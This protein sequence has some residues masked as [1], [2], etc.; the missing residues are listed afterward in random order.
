M[1]DEGGAMLDDTNANLKKIVAIVGTLCLAVVGSA[2]WDFA[3]KPLFIWM[4][5]W[6]TDIANLG[7]TALSD[8][9][10]TEIARGN[11]ER[12]GSQL[13]VLVLGI[14][15]AVPFIN[16]IWASRKR[17]EPVKLTSTDIRFRYAAAVILAGAFLLQS[18]RTLYMVRAANHLDQLQRIVA[19]YISQEKRIDIASRIAEI[20]SRQDYER[21]VNEMSAVMI[22][23][24]LKIP[25]FDLK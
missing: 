17:D 19:P 21:I 11:Y 20:R 4:G 1:A 3:F 12:A 5:G 10:Y 7:S 8:S 6:L 23:Q 22:S 13:F 15:A 2:L 18:A 24:K 16:L 14:M 25:T 9:M